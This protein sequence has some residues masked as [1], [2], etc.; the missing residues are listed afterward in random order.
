MRIAV[1]DVDGDGDLDILLGAAQVPIGIPAGHVARY[2]QLLQ[3]KASLLLL[4]NRT[5]PPGS[6]RSP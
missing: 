4:R 5:R 6:T 2:E 3:G 1:G